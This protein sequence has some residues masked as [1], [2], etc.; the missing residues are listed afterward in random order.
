MVHP[1]YAVLM[2][3]NVPLGESAPQTMAVSFE[4]PKSIPASAGREVADEF[5][6]RRR[7][8]VGGARRHDDAVHD[9]RDGALVVT[10]LRARGRSSERRSISGCLK[11]GAASSA[12]RP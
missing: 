2:I 3:T 1:D 7:I 8:E 11:T 9:L 5:G 12:R 10:T 4:A 6:D